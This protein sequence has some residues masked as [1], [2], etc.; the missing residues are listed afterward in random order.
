MLFDHNFIVFSCLRNQRHLTMVNDS[1]APGIFDG[2]NPLLQ[3]PNNPVAEEQ[4]G[5]KVKKGPS[6]R[7]KALPRLIALPKMFG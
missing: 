1:Q 3:A 7:L 2:P 6:S 4:G 5:K